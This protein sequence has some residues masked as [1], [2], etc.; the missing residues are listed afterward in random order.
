MRQIYRQEEEGQT[1]RATD[2]SQQKSYDG[3]LLIVLEVKC[4]LLMRGG[5]RNDFVQH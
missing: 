5:K 2:I 1:D 4:D 3:G